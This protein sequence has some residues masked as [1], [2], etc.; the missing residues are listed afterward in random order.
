VEAVV[1]DAEVVGELV[2]DG[3]A[4]LGDELL[5]GVTEGFEGAAEEE[6]AI[7]EGEVV[8]GGADGEG[9]ALVEAEE[10]AAGADAG[11]AEFGGGGPFADQD[12]DVVQAA[13]E[14]GG[15]PFDGLADERLE[16]GGAGEPAS[17]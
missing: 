13:Q 8:A 3:A 2:E 14:F 11:R 15:Q 4:D 9:G 16:A 1:V 5:V 7:G 12:V 6:D 10:H 17:R